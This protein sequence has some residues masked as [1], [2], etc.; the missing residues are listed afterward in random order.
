MLSTRSSVGFLLSHQRL[1]I[2]YEKSSKTFCCPASPSAGPS[3]RGRFE[4]LHAPKNLH[5]SITKRRAEH[6]VIRQENR[7]KIAGNQRAWR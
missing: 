5:A 3:H 2:F 4:I 6:S 1:T 7:L